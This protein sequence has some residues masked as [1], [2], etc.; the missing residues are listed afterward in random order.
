MEA[1][2]AM[3]ARSRQP[4]LQTG[5]RAGADT[6]GV[7]RRPRSGRGVSYIREHHAPM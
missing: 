1:R 7:Y 4:A 5:E 3:L 6:D 2:A